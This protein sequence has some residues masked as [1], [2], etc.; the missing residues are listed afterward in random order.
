VGL[1]LVPAVRPAFALDPASV[2][3]SSLEEV[4]VT[5]Q[6]KTERTQDVPIPLSVIEPE[7][8]INSNQL[9]VQDYY[10]TVPSVTINTDPTGRVNLVIRGIT[11]GGGPPTVGIV[12]DDVPFGGSSTLLGASVPDFDPSDLQRIEVLRGPQ[13]TLYG[14]DTLGGLFR[15]VTVDPSTKAFSG[16]VSAG[17]DTVFN[18]PH[19]GYNVRG[20]V[21]VP[22]TDTLAV[23]IS[24]FTHTDPGYVDNILTGERGVNKVETSGGHITALWRPSEDLS[25][26]LSALYQ[27]AKGFGTSRAFQGPGYG[28]LQQSI[29]A[30]TE[31]FE[32]KIQAYS[33]TLTAKLGGVTLTSLSGFNVTHFTD[34]VDLSHEFGEPGSIPDNYNTISASQEFRLAASVGSNLDWLLGVFYNNQHND[35]RQNSLAEDI[36]LTGTTT[37]STP[38]SEYAGFVNVVYRFTDRI[39]LQVGARESHLKVSYDE[40]DTGF[41]AGLP[42]PDDV[43]IVPHQTTT[44]NAFTYLLTPRFKVNSDLMLYARLASGYRPGGPNPNCVINDVPCSVNPDKTLTYDLGTKGTFFDQKLSLDLALYYID[45]KNLQLSIAAPSGFGYQANAGHAKSQGIELSADAHPLRGMTIAGWVDFSDAALKAGFPARSGAYGQSG[46]RLP[47]SS[48]FSVSVSIDQEFPLTA[49][50][51]GFAG[52]SVRY[53]SEREDLFQSSAASVRPVFPGFAQT[54]FRLGAKWDAWTTNLYATNVTDRRGVI[55]GHATDNS[56]IYIQPRTIGVNFTRTF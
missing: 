56:V 14:A 45:W 47:Y 6:K 18:A 2:Q 5:A 37:A 12:V 13:G 24:G 51:R 23:R 3:S 28:D 34:Q 19:L 49:S 46:D 50:I 44:A 20:S 39:D 16:Q 10:T 40:R 9:R 53:L 31:W 27:D 32:T 55:A 11:T 15:Y 4:V 42:T 30:G 8:L 1:F 26:K 36:A 33:A 25:L 17:T 38:F 35:L 54:D 22:A 43:S 21:N 48:R 41:W 52:G 29:L 7:S